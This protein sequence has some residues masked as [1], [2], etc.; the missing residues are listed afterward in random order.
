MPVERLKTMHTDLGS[1]DRP[2]I[3][4]SAPGPLNFVNVST[5]LLSSGYS[6]RFRAPGDSM[7]PFIMDG[8]AITV[9][10]VDPLAVKRGDIIL[11][12]FKGGVIAHSV[13]RIRRRQ[14]GEPLFILR[15]DLLCSADEPVEPQQ[16]LGRVVSVQRGGRSIYLDSTRA[17]MMRT[18]Y[19]LAFRLK[20]WVVGTFFD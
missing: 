20:R 1:M 13:V 7:R 4:C 17:R 11:Y 3:R 9:S 6:V 2:Y 10:P 19:T 5:G 16:I 15:G 12:C 18:A 14:D 8:D